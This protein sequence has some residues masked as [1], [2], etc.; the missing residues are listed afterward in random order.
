MKKRALSLLL[1]L[2]VLAATLPAM[3]ATAAARVFHDIPKTQWYAG[4]VYALAEKGVISGINDTTFPPDRYVSRAEFVKMLAASVV[5]TS[6]VNTYKDMNLFSDVPST[7]WYAPYVNW[8][9]QNGIANG[10]NG[11]FR[12]NGNVTREEAASFM[13]RLANAYP[14]KISLDAKTAQVSFP[15]EADI[16]N[17]AVNDVYTCQKA[18][19]VSGTG[20][21]SF[22]PKG[23]TSR[24]QAAVMLC[25]LLNIT[26]FSGS[27]I[28]EPPVQALPFKE[29]TTF[30]QSVAGVWA[31]GVQFNPANGYTAKI[32]I[33]NNKFYTA[34]SASSIV[35]KNNGYVAVNGAFF[36]SYGDQNMFG[37]VINNG[38]IVRVYN[39]AAPY[40][41]T[42]V[43][44]KNGKASIQFM[45]INQ[46]VT[47]VK[48]GADITSFQNVG[49]NMKVGDADGTRMIYTKEFGATLS[50]NIV[51][52]IVVD[53]KG[54][55]TKV[56]KGS[57]ANVAIPADG[58]LLMERLTRNGADKLFDECEVGD[59]L[60]L[61][62]SYEGSSTQE[63]ATALSCGPTL[64]KS[65]KPYGNP[66][67]YAQ[68]G[69]NDAHVTSGSAARMAIGVKA[70]GTVVIASAS[71]SLSGMSQ[72]MAGL[73]CQTAMNLDGGASTAL[74]VKGSWL[75]SP[76][77]SL[78]NM[79]I[80]SKK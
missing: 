72:V 25:R 48:D 35:S 21:G 32:G 11:R 42:F 65:G 45:T 44:D 6:E 74:Y 22:S 64:V 12:P 67:T 56:Y 15:D 20:N 13:V 3:T 63:I 53:G 1:A 59:Q 50:G 27:Q 41:P 16:S 36:N 71:C 80:F 37:T 26:P 14:E 31:T 19:I 17:W 49:S 54:T 55:V 60:R 7:Q 62:V 39:D 34:E 51:R 75:A 8:A 24:S 33:A 79:L 52:G 10:S 18:G 73:G 61:S 70:D 57:T 77:R 69:F 38:R 66:S 30:S 40:K 68:E 29:P 43:V 47:L 46:T 23:K 76:G 58:F 9:A 28:P 5:S 4:S 2:V 78:S